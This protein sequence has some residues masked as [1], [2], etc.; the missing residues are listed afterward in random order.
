MGI[1]LGN[2]TPTPTQGLGGGMGE[3]S[4]TASTLTPAPSPVNGILN[5]SKSQTLDFTKKNPGLTTVRVGLGWD[6]ASLGPSFDLDASAFLLGANGKC[7]DATHICYFNNQNAHG[8]KSLGDNRTGQ[9]EGDDETILVY[10][11][12]LPENIVKVK[13]VV[14]IFEAIQK[15]QNFGMVKNAYIRLMDDNTGAELCRFVLTD[16][17]ST[18]TALIF[19]EV[20]RQSDGNWNFNTLGEGS[21]NDL[22][23]LAGLFV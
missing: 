18:S 9:G 1:N 7:P 20:E 8:V 22:N 17:Y 4:T 23:G 13:F 16:D 21:V 10:L 5:M 2:S 6:T 14:T 11:S 3:T 12:Q 15:K 19:A